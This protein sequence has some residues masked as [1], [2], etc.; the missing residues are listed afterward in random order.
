MKFSLR[1]NNDLPIHEYVALAQAAE[2]V[3]F[4]QFWVS[5]DLF[6]RSALVILAAVAQATQRIEIG[7]GI[8][9]PYTLHPAEIAMFAA[10]MDE[11]S[12]NRF[13]LGIAAGAGEFLKWVGIEQQTPLAATRET[14][15]AIRRL[16]QGERVALAGHFL[17][18]NEEAYLR[19]PAPRVTPIYL[20]AMGPKMLSLA[21]ALADGVLPLLFPP[22]HYFAVAPYLVQGQA[23]RDTALPSLDFA[24]C[25]WVSLAEDRVAARHVLAQKIAYYGHALGPLILA[26]LGLTQADFRP[27]E[28]A[29]MVE[30]DEAKAI[31]LVDE[32]M[33]RIGVVGGSDDVIARLEPLVAAGANHLSFG[34]PLGPEPHRAIQLLGK[35]ITHFRPRRPIN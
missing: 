11:V 8:L 14:I 28:Q 17:H 9:N 24:A 27:I 13:N 6:L 25:I 7:T 30:R 34:P 5:N 10:T 4:D 29:I 12:S 31:R 33:L 35:V 19:F 32:R 18:W 23:E 15:Q 3:G 21:G 26:R 22:E 1:L 2:A 20:G 16:L